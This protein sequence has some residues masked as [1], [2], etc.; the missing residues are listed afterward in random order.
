MAT[1][2]DHEKAMKQEVPQMQGSA[3]AGKQLTGASFA[4]MGYHDLDA[5][6]EQH[7]FSDH[8]GLVVDIEEA[9]RE[10]GEDVANKLKLA[11]DGRTILW[12]R[13]LRFVVPCYPACSLRALPIVRAR[14]AETEPNFPLARRATF[15]GMD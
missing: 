15:A 14:I 8:T 13:E 1:T 3:P 4:P 10:F 7:G 12:P 9:R 6:A 11:K 2:V 5:I